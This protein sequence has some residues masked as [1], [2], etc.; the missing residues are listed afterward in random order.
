MT[1]PTSSDAVTFNDFPASASQ[2][3]A[4]DQRDYDPSIIADSKLAPRQ[5]EAAATA[6][7]VVSKEYE[8][9]F[10]IGL[11]TTWAVFPA[12]SGT[13]A[14]SILTYRLIPSLGTTETLQN[15]FEKFTAAKDTV[16]PDPH[17]HQAYQ[18]IYDLL[19]L[20]T[21]LSRTFDL[22]NAQRNRYHR[23]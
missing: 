9:K 8:E 13:L 22:I 15:L 23:G 17:D 10:T 14:S 12:L 4:R 20:L 16:S 7:Y 5:T 2:R 19:H 21:S 11:L 1:T 18:A 3:Y 6:P